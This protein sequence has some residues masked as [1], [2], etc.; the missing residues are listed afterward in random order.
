MATGFRDS[1]KDSDFQGFTTE[2][3]LL[4]QLGLTEYFP[5]TLSLEDVREHDFE[6]AARDSREIKWVLISKL[7]GLNSKARDVELEQYFKENAKRTNLE[8]IKENSSFDNLYS[9][10]M[11]QFSPVVIANVQFNPLDVLFTIFCCCSPFL[12]QIIITKM[13]ICRL[14]V[15]FISTEWIY[16]GQPIIW[17]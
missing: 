12:K 5:E 9:S 3:D 7:I 1:I 13:F 14:A 8:Q 15:P 11:K 4:D 2:N 17:L 10:V 6:T 16:V